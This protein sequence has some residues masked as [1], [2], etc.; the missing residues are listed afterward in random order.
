[1]GQIHSFWNEFTMRR[2][3][4]APDIS[5]PRGVCSTRAN[6]QSPQPPA[7]TMW[8][9]FT[10]DGDRCLR[11]GMIRASQQGGGGDLFERCSHTSCSPKR[12]EGPHTH[13]CIIF[14][15]NTYAVRAMTGPKKLPDHFYLRHTMNEQT[16]GCWWTQRRHLWPSNN[17]CRKMVF[18]FLLLW[19]LTEML[20]VVDVFTL[21]ISRIKKKMNIP[22]Q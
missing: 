18:L 2:F 7:G 12:K 3:I 4:G 6:C 15:P 17:S 21:E 1:M 9:A 16:P 14:P 8:T 5:I 19:D 20:Q 13:R 11:L 10:V 22:F